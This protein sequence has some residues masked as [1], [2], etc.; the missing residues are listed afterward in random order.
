MSLFIIYPKLSY[1]RNVFIIFNDF[2]R[3]LDLLYGATFIF[4]SL[5]RLAHLKLLIYTYI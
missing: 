4:V 5:T 1:F 2:Q 3:L